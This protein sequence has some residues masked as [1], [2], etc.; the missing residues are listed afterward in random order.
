MNILEFIG[1]FLGIPFVMLGIAGGYLSLLD[2]IRK[3]KVDRALHGEKGVAWYRLKKTVSDEFSEHHFLIVGDLLHILPTLTK[4]P[5][6]ELT[7]LSAVGEYY[8]VV[9]RCKPEYEFRLVKNKK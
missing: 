5:D 2:R 9:F 6:V 8:E 7:Q 4:D 1:A 3:W